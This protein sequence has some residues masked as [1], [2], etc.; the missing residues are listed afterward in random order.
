MR[1][2]G[3]PLANPAQIVPYEAIGTGVYSPLTGEYTGSG[4]GT[5][6]GR[7]TFV[8]YVATSPTANPLVFNFKST[9]PQM[10]VAANGDTIDFTSS[11]Q[12]QLIPLDQTMTTFTAIWTGEFVVVGGTGRFANVEPGRKPLQVIALNDPFTFED[13][14]WAFSWFLG[15]TIDLH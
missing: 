13:P 10:T 11:G 2:S 8:G 14:A 7:H 3:R 5:P 15:G 4:L 9:V 6:L 1:F 12:V